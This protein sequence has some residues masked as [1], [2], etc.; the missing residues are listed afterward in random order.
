MN[1]TI[2][3]PHYKTGKMTAYAV[4]KLL[5]HKGRHRVKI[6]VIDNGGG[7]GLEYLDRFGKEVKVLHY[8]T[9]KLQSH[10]IAFDFAMSEVKTEYFIT[11]ESDSFPTQD[12]WLDYYEDLTSKG[13]HC[14]GSLLKLSGGTYIHPAG[15]LYCR[16]FYNE[17]AEYK[18]PYHYFP[19]M[20]FKDNFHYHV[21][22][23]MGEPLHLDAF[24]LHH[25]YQNKSV[26]EIMQK[27]VDYLPT[28][29]VFHN[30][31][32]FQDDHIQTYGRRDMNSDSGPL[33]HGDHDKMYLRVGYEPG[34]WFCYYMASRGKNIY[35]IPTEIKWLPG[36][37]NQQQEYTIMENGFKHLWGVS[38]YNG[39]TQE[40]IQDIVKFKERQVEELWETINT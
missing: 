34:Q 18:Y 32:G 28:T 10:G 27:A 7:E 33:L 14:A 8:P 9:G 4:H 37:E 22:W 2:L 21:M 3:L 26:E 13:F 1:V 31:M 38:A 15:A 29:G 30:G 6:I 24:T 5:Q 23:P 19:N 36:R 35:P 17:A 11:V 25:S 16:S 39:C 40:D 20:I 12:N